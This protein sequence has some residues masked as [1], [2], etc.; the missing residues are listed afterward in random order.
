[1]PVQIIASDFYF[2]LATWR[3]QHRGQRQPNASF[4]RR[5]TRLCNRVS[6]Q[7]SWGAWRLSAAKID[8][9]LA[10]LGIVA[11]GL[12][13][14]R[15]SFK[16]IVHLPKSASSTSNAG[17]RLDNFL[18]LRMQ[19]SC[20]LANAHPSCNDLPHRGRPIHISKPKVSLL[21]E[22]GKL[23]MRVDCNEGADL[24]KRTSEHNRQ[25]QCG[26]CTTWTLA[27][28]C[29]LLLVAC[30]STHFR[31]PKNASHPGLNGVLSVCPCLRLKA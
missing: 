23:Y 5:T 8:G 29:R 14:L 9:M 7:A 22:L 1:M 25:L 13:G 10:G 21:A 11:N 30:I 2:Y 24:K 3:A 31:G 27:P 12:D 6:D 20:N 15:R 4:P 26:Y 19:A 17:C 16:R 28:S 18:K